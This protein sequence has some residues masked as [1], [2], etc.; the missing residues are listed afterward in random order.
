LVKTFGGDIFIFSTDEMF[1][2][3][4]LNRKAVQCKMFAG[5]LETLTSILC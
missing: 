4:Q 3:K 1:E 5:A 2:S